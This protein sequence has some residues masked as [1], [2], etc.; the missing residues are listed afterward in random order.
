MNGPNPQPGPNSF[1]SQ[2]LCINLKNSTNKSNFGHINPKHDVAVKP[3]VHILGIR[4]NLLCIIAAAAAA[5]TYDGK[6]RKEHY[7]VQKDDLHDANY[8]VL[9]KRQECR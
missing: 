2:C 6:A 8:E 4:R 1:S 9:D 3:T 7:R 5:A